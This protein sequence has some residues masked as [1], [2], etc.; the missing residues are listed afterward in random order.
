ME[1]LQK[2]IFEANVYVMTPKGR[3]IDLP[4]GATPLDFAYRIHTEIG[5]TTVGAIVNDVMVPLNTVLHTGDVVNIKT[6]KGTGP[7]EDWLNV[8]KTN[9]AK[10]K[11]KAYFQKKEAQLKEERV[12][13]GERLLSEEL[14]KRG[15]DPKEYLDKKKIIEIM[16]SFQCQNYTEVMYGLAVHD[17]NMQMFIDKLTNQKTRASEMATLSKVLKREVV[18][19]V[20]K[21]GL[22]VPGIDSI[23]MSLAYCCLPVYGDKIVGNITKTEGVKVHR[24]DCPNAKQKGAHLIDVYWD[25]ESSDQTYQTDLLVHAS[26]R[27]FLLTDIVTVVSQCRLNLEAINATT[28]HENLTASFKLSLRVKNIEQL[29]N[30]IANIR[31]LDSIIS[32]ERKTH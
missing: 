18:K 19:K 14:R 25:K 27:N 3:V 4:S 20:S 10:S 13:D 21:T 9:Q 11:I 26:D 22:I 30:L 12:S 8:V 31:K 7:S 15:F 6:L 17:I 2:D 16:N 23:K 29:E 5:H 28:N 32:V 24:A 1:T